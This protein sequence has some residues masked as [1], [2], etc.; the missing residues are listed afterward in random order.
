VNDL[1]EIDDFEND[2][3]TKLP[4][5][6]SKLRDVQPRGFGRVVNFKEDIL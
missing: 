3:V 4:N 1:E 6:V 5:L 2:V